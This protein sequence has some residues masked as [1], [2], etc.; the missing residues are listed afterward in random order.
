MG[1]F[2]FSAQMVSVSARSP[3]QVRQ[4]RFRFVGQISAAVMTAISPASKLSHLMEPR[5][6][7]ERSLGVCFS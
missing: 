5:R 2:R 6:G 3:G 7:D 1:E 4:L